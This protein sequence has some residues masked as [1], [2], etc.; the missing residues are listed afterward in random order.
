M[1]RLSR[2]D[3]DALPYGV[4]RLDDEGRILG[5]NPAERSA[6]GVNGLVGKNFFSEVAPC[7]D[8]QEFHGRFES[9][10]GSSERLREFN[11]TYRFADEVTTRVRI[12]FVRGND[13]AM[14]IVRKI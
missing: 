8:V 6:A 7:T 1:G 10:L 12:V 3:L 2:Q 11:F 9:F 13:G 14:L 4:I 5:M